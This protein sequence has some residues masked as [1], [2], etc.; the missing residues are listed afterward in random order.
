MC[1]LH[2]AIWDA[3]SWAFCPDWP[4]TTILLISA[5]QVVR[6]AGISQQHLVLS[7]FCSTEVFNF[8]DIQ[9]STFS[10]MDYTFS[11]ISR[12]SLLNQRSAQF[13]LSLFPSSFQVFNGKLSL[14]WKIWSSL[15]LFSYHI[16]RPHPQSQLEENL[17]WFHQTTLI[18][19]FFEFLKL[20]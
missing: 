8:H 13:S 11:I 7:I 9:F 3:V 10:F 16:K 19:S 18:L 15:V 1:P 4:W 6:I 17:F 20:Q 5:S 2:P 12:K 14:L